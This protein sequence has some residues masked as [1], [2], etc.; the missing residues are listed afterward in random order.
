MLATALPE[1]LSLSSWQDHV[2]LLGR[3]STPSQV[4]EAARLRVERSIPRERRPPHA[5]EPVAVRGAM[6]AARGRADSERAQ[7]DPVVR[8]GCTYA[9]KPAHTYSLHGHRHV[10]YAG[11]PTCGPSVQ[12]RVTTESPDDGTH[13]VYFNRGVA[14]S[15]AHEGGSTAERPDEV[16]NRRGL[17]L[18]LAR[19]RGGDAGA[20]I[21]Q[22]VDSCVAIRAATL[23]VRV[24]ARA[25]RVQDRG[26]AGAD[27]KI[28]LDDR[29][30]GPDRRV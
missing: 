13:G 8:M 19:A 5:R 22:A 29:E 26:D 12:A 30:A 18:A 4:A 28:V 15:A 21:G 11:G 17:H 25:R 14:A 9:A 2:V 23:R 6:M 27:V 20:V 16:A 1:P 3:A 7:P 10:R 24:P